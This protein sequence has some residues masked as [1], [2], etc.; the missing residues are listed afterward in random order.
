MV[1]QGEIQGT[2]DAEDQQLGALK[3]KVLLCCDHQVAA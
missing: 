3:E 1:S 2:K